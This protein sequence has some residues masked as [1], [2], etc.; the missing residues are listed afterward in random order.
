[1]LLN[2]LKDLT[3]SIDCLHV[4]VIN[5][6][7]YAAQLSAKREAII[8]ELVAIGI[9]VSEARKMVP[10][11][12]VDV[13]WPQSEPADEPELP[14]QDADLPTAEDV[15]GILKPY[16]ESPAAAESTERNASQVAAAGVTDEIGPDSAAVAFAPAPTLPPSGQEPAAF[17]PVRDR[18][19]FLNRQK[20]SA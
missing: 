17:D 4:E 19:E 6:E 16:M 13:T 18:P 10:K 8:A 3:A 12:T 11:I 1:M 5:L 15:R 20:A 14:L 2:K 9:K 7:D